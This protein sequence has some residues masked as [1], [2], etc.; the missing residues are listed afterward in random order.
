MAEP[1]TAR[2]A[3]HA[4][5][6][7]EAA[8]FTCVGSATPGYRTCSSTGTVTF[9]SGD[10]HAE[11]DA[12]VLSDGPEGR[13]LVLYSGWMQRG[14]QPRVQFDTATLTPAPSVE[15]AGLST[16]AGTG[17][18]TA[19]SA[20]SSAAGLSAEGLR[21]APCTCDD[22]R[23]T[24]LTLS[25]KSAE[26]GHD[27]D[28]NA[29]FVLV[30]GG[31]VR[32]FDVPVLPL[33]HVRVPLDPD[34]FHLLIP[35][36]GYG[37]PGLSASMRGQI[38]FDGWRVTGGPAWRQDRGGR[39]ELDA[40]GP[41]PGVD[42]LGGSGSG[43]V[44]YDP[45]TGTVRGA[46][47][48]RG[49]VVASGGAAP[50]GDR[51]GSGAPDLRLAWD[52]D[53]TSD[54][55]YAEDYGSDWVSRGLPRQEQRA[56]LGFGPAR[57]SLDRATSLSSPEGA[58]TRPIEQIEARVRKEVGSG[59]TAIALRAAVGGW[60]VDA[61]DLAPLGELG[62]DARGAWSGG[63]LRFSGAVDGAA[64]G[65][66]GEGLV[67]LGRGS[68]SAE[69]PMWTGRL[70]LWPGVVSA[71]HAT[72]RPDGVLGQVDGNAFVG[73][74]TRADMVV[75]DW[76]FTGSGHV[77]QDEQGWTGRA[78]LDLDGPVHLALRAGRRQQGGEIGLLT[79]PV[80]VSVGGLHRTADDQLIAWGSADLHLSRFR[81]GGSLSTPLGTGSPMWSSRLLA[82]YDDGCT[83]LLVTAALSPDRDFPDLGLR[84][85]VRR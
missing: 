61:A 67:G 80:S 16:S 4:P 56:V 21:Y 9:Q 29:I 50:G 24:A 57:L 8:G 30:R 44:G 5:V 1:V 66:T 7:V 11:A 31:T 45:I 52:A 82:G 14:T 13:R 41:A 75:G 71:G 33:P 26:I 55:A 62:L 40:K 58:L 3:E 42:Q 73:A 18:L 60:G 85:E 78:T 47:T 74:G 20:T 19:D 35:E 25:A 79:Q 68:A 49:G 6:E 15:W 76:L 59:A 81:V 77:G 63:P 28:G 27:A 51:P 84:A 38:G 65:T 83:R 70:Q 43:A 36:V 10:V 46:V 69:L 37:T 48:S 23:P 72:A 22:G 2:A 32:L 64:R 34:R 12:A 54:T 17:Q 53:W 39:L